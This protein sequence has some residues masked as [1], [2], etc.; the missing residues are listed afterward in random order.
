VISSGLDKKITG[1]VGS[2]EINMLKNHYADLNT[3]YLFKPTNKLFKNISPKQKYLSDEALQRSIFEPYSTEDELKDRIE[4][5][6][7]NV[8]INLL[9]F[10]ERYKSLDAIYEHIRSFSYHEL[11]NE[12]ILYGGWPVVQFDAIILAKYGGLTDRYDIWLDATYSAINKYKTDVNKRQKAENVERALEVLLQRLNSAPQTSHVVLTDTEP[13]IMDDTEQGSDPLILPS[14]YMGFI[15]KDSLT[16]DLSEA[17]KDILGGNWTLSSEDII[18]QDAVDETMRSSDISV[19]EQGG[20]LLCIVSNPDIM[21]QIS[22][23]AISAG[24]HSVLIYGAEDV[25][26]L[27]VLRRFDKGTETI[28]HVDADSNIMIDHR[29]TGYEST[30]SIDEQ[31]RTQIESFLGSSL[32]SLSGAAECRVYKRC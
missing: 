16:Q 9:P 21:Q 6:K 15:I 4:R 2:V 10:F 13:D 19:Y 5:F 18:L 26:G 11:M 30:A 31:I 22:A 28:H 25:S 29:A 7:K 1:G 23:D 3:K 8:E 12:S 14:S 24:Q 32:T 17:L 27:R 20:N